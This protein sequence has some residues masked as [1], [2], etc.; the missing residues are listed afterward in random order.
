MIR[1]KLVVV[2]NGGDTSGHLRAIH[3]KETLHLGVRVEG[4]LLLVEQVLLGNAQRRRPVGI[5]PVMLVWEF[6]KLPQRSSII[7]ANHGQITH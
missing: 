6:E 4:M 5:E 3:R 7:S 1:S 2:E